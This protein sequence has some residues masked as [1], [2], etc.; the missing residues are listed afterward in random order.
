M[1]ADELNKI[2][3][4]ENEARGQYRH[5]V[6][7]CVAAGCLSA[8]SDQVKDALEKEVQRRGLDRHCQVRG[9]GCLG[10][11]AEGPLV[12]VE[13]KEKPGAMYQHVTGQDAAELVQ[14]LDAPQP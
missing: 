1:T 2:A 13:S 10:L 8:R 5:N 9:V 14:A 12:S 4:I 3:L 6:N 7:V 11:C